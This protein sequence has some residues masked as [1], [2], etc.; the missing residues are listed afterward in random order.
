MV[1]IRRKHARHGQEFATRQSRA[2]VLRRPA[3]QSRKPRQQ[4][5]RGMYKQ[6]QAAQKGTKPT[7]TQGA[8]RHVQSA[9]EIDIT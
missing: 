5:K 3:R 6:D 2:R 9:I 4:G 1:D 8:A 7:A